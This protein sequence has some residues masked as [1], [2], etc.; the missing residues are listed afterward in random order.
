MNSI[1][2]IL[3][4]LLS[5]RCL[6]C[7]CC[8]ITSRRLKT[9]ERE[10]HIKLLLSF[11][12]SFILLPHNNDKT[13]ERNLSVIKQENTLFS[14]CCQ[15]YKCYCFTIKLNFDLDNSCR[16]FC[17]ISKFYIFFLKFFICI[18]IHPCGSNKYKHKQTKHRKHR[19]LQFDH[20][21]GYT[22]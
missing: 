14:F 8:A 6:L 21:I 10:I 9:M 13:T 22:K 20:N 12:R 4:Y 3:L 19:K 2:S 5:F 17:W 7:F 15:I 18:I 1:T 11:L 16:Q